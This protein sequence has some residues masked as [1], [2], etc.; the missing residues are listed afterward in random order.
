MNLL[1]IVIICAMVL[2]IVKG[3]LRGFIRETASLAGVVLGILLGHHFQ[4]QLGAHLKSYLPQTSLLPVISFSVIFG[5]VLISCNL[6]GYLFKLLFE[7]SFLG[8]L[9]R[10]LGVGLAV[11]KGI[12]LTYLAI[13]LLTFF[14]PAKTPLIA[15][16]KLAP[17]IVVSYQSM[18]RLISP[19]HYERWKTKIL[20]E[21]HREGKM[22]SENVEEMIKKK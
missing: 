4:P 1:D 10:T 3:L 16:S 22:V 18:V 19:E 9:D 17:W 2:L 20:G 8:W 15:R 7:K 21:T 13:V 5:F 11:T 14:V 12:I 6:L